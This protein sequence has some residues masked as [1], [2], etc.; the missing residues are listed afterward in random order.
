M[1]RLV[2]L[3]YRK[4]DVPA[5]VVT[6]L[7]GLML[8]DAVETEGDDSVKKKKKK[9]KSSKDVECTTDKE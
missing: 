1:L 7:Q 3:F 5:D 6:K 2:L 8:P 4:S 9:K